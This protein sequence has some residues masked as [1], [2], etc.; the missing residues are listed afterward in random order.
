MLSIIHRPPV[1]WSPMS[2]SLNSPL[3][4]RVN[5][6]MPTARTSG[7]ANGSLIK[8]FSALL[9]NARAVAI[10]VAGAPT[11]EARSQV[12]LSVRVIRPLLPRSF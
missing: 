11:L 10:I 6:S 4:S 3:A 7:S 9:A 8:G 1:A 12:S 5:R 2:S